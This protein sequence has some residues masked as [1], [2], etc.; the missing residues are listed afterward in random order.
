MNP[1][2]PPASLRRPKLQHLLA[3]LFVPVVFYFWW[4]SIRQLK[5]AE[6]LA[7]TQGNEGW[8][9]AGL[10]FAGLY[11][12]GQAVVWRQI[13]VDLVTQVAWL[14]ALRV[15][16]ISNMGRYLPG[17]VWHLV[18]RVMIGQDA[19]VQKSSGALGVILEQALQL[20]SALLIVG[21]SL[22][23]WSPDSIVGQ[24]K[25]LAWFVPLGL[26]AIHPRLFF[27][28]LNFGLTKLGKAPIPNTLTYGMMVRYTLYY[29]LVHL[30]NGL[31]LVAAVVALGHPL[32]LAPIV[33][34]S[35]MFAWTLGYLIIFSPGGLGVREF[36]VTEALAPII[37][38]DGAAVAA[39]LWRAANIITEAVGA[40]LFAL[41]VRP[42]APVRQAVPK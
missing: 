3:Y 29:I 32:S 14:P 21:A 41:L 37:G 30:C 13:V 40:G 17:S 27:P 22:P 7:Q 1:Q 42:P 36:F 25:W 23:F 11:L 6:N 16:M 4:Q 33:L 5:L 18:G 34:G 15:W 24:Y 9:V 2:P 31:A 39:L 19:G 12:L 20:F 38:R 8:L 28:I 26:V 35:A 10:G